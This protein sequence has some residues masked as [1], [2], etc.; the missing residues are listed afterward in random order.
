MK[1]VI[2]GS[3]NVAEALA[4]ALTQAGLPPV[5]IF[6]R[7]YAK[8]TRVATRAAGFAHSAAA[9]TVCAATRTEVAICPA[10]TT[11][12][13]VATNS[14]T[15]QAAARVAGRCPVTDDPRELAEADL[16]II[17]VADKAIAGV[18]A[19]LDLGRAGRTGRSVVAHTAGSVGLDVFPPD[20][21]N[22]AVFYP[23]QTFSRGRMI[24][25]R[26]VPIL[27]EGRNAHSL[28]IVREVAEALSDSVIEADSAR[29][30]AAHLA[31]VFTNN[32]TNYMYTVGAQLAAEAGLD[33]GLLK[34]LVRETAAKA[35]EANSPVAVQTGPAVRNDFR[36]R[37][38]HCEMLAAK[39]ELQNLYINISKNIWEISKKR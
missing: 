24:D 37:S 30:A 9:V 31:A 38:R 26:S 17:A 34:P 19:S 7:S 35:L 1:I 32:F 20:V 5:Q 29:R 3:G 10:A 16:Y 11:H 8:A 18:A 33:F 4:C 14:A 28:K 25:M 13:A 27:V 6:A 36:T 15:V 23:L 39:P 21:R 2:I 12:S 22:A